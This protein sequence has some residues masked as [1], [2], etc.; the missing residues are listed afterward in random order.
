[1]DK[2][3][4][5]NYAVEARRKLI[6]AVK[7]KAQQLYIFEDSAKTL[8]PNAEIERL[9]AD[10]IFLSAD[11]LNARRRLY[12]ELLHED[13]PYK[14]AIYNRVM[15]SV[16]C[17]WFNR[18]IALRIMEVNEWL[19]SNTRIL[20]SQEPGR[21]EP[22]ALREV[23]HLDFVNQAKVAELRADTGINA[24]EKL[25]KYILISQC[26][27]LHKIL[28]GMFEKEN[29]Y[30]ELLLP[31]ALLSKGGIVHDL[32][33]M[34]HE[35]NFHIEK[36]GQIEIIGWLYQFY[37]SEKKDEVN[38]QKKNVT[39]NKDTIPA[40]TQLF[41]PQWIVKYMVENSLGRLWLDRDKAE[42]GLS[43]DI[44]NASY[45]GWKYYIEDAEQTPEVAEQLRVLRSQ[46][47]IKRPEDIKLIDPCMGS[48]HILVYA[49][50]VL[51]Q[52]YLSQGYA[53]REIPNLILQNNLYGLDID[54]RAGQL[55][56]FALM[57][58][59][60]SYNRRFFRQDN[61]PQ[62][63]VYSFPERKWFIVGIEKWLGVSMAESDRKAAYQDLLYLAETLG[64]DKGKTF[65]S[66]IKIERE[67]D[68]TRLRKYV[69][70]F[71]TGQIA[72]DDT[73]FMS[74]AKYFDELIDIAEVLAQKYDVV[75]TNPPYMAPAPAQADWVKKNY[76]DTKSDLCVVFIERNF[77]F[78]K[79]NGYLSMITMHSWMFLSSYEKFREK[80]IATKDIINMAHLGARAF[81]EIGGEVVQTTAFVMRRS[82]V[83]GYLGTYARLVD[84]P[85]QDV[86]EDAFLTGGNRYVANNRNFEKI[87]GA[88]VAYWAKQGI[89]DAFG[90][91]TP[92]GTLTVTRNGMKTGDNERFL[93]FWW[94]VIYSSLKVDA[95]TAQIAISSNAKW[96]P[97]N[98]GG[99]SRKWYGNNDYVVNWKDG[100]VEIFEH[101]KADKRNVQD[102]PQEMK[103]KPS[104]TW[105]LINT[106]TPTF[107]YKDCNLSD[108]AGMSFY[109][110]GAFTKYYLAFCNTPIA[111]NILQL[112]AP[113]INYQ[114][115]DIGRLPI[116]YS[117]E[118]SEKI[119]LKTENN[120]NQA[121]QDWDSFETS[122]DFKTHPLVQLSMAG[123]FSWGDDEPTKRLSSAYKA[124]EM[125]CE[126]RFS[127]LKANEEELNRIFIDIYGLQ[128]ELTPEVEDKD[129]TIRKADL[130]RDIRSFISYAVG[131]M[132]GRYSIY[133]EGLLY[134]GG[135]S[136]HFSNLVEK[137]QDHL[138]AK[139]LSMFPENEFYP[140]ND[141]ILPIGSADYFEDD[142]VVR[143][144]EFV[145]T[146]YGNETLSEN[147][148][149]IADAL[150][151]TGNGSAQEKIRRY[152]LNDFYKDHLKI[153]QKRPIYWLLDSGKKDG[154]KALFYLHRYDKYT[155]ARVRTDYLH[156]LQRKYEAEI[157]QLEMLATATDNARDKA[158]YRKEIDALQAKIDECRTYDQ[159][160]SHIAHQ[161]IELDLD[162]GVKVNY[163][164]FQSVEVPKDNGKTEKMDL[165]AKI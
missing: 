104:G 16:A 158:A 78:L 30:T 11:Q 96:F 7:L 28:P 50:E 49:F 54:D 48:G 124:W 13:M 38:A 51:Y 102:Y 153:Y 137:I 87:P 121:K 117:Q 22:D 23:D 160:V 12:D 27:A 126:G 2:T 131:C 113:T 26:N 98:K 92:L 40:V 60:R 109:N 44:M 148:N 89:S 39:I 93:R 71:A 6:E 145:R 18:L 144:V 116:I 120:I 41:T 33:N 133:T 65:G 151:P 156:P 73:D 99:E 142:I 61:I 57:I 75:V 110:G 47:P 5:R 163:E 52:I 129:V 114:A 15:E 161:Q 90:K 82:H 103:F 111:T 20:S 35:D 53:E 79:Q 14:P 125:L 24:S 132:F 1:M 72:M 135:G 159:V 154:F 76:P 34:I 10:G 55:A 68:F 134:A 64:D 59:A 164:K 80:L 84:Y 100:G 66:A 147:L 128:D 83:S 32:V 118:Y 74:Q 106:G 46:S 4:I 21:V 162:D 45:Y 112:I 31:D 165:L 127:Q 8:R 36:Q 58:K 95:Q 56:Y 130:G 69:H 155:I 152:F 29:D 85:G 115:G 42:S 140:E 149:F 37:I 101:A 17:T 123:A 143:F 97:Y 119:T 122:W 3:A 88:P 150:Y 70:D 63:M 107:R 141:N 9:Q 25:Y 108:I 19:P 138:R 67:I 91:G 105:S 81:E 146:V 86:K 43:D 139:G 77:G 157:K 62:P 94:E 136:G